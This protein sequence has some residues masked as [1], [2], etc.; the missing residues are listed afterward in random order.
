MWGKKR[1]A[2]EMKKNTKS[3]VVSDKVKRGSAKEKTLA[4]SDWGMRFADKILKKATE[5]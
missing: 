3:R 5:D 1:E 4:L 2:N